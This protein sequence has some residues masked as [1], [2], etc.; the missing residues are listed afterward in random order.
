MRKLQE[1]RRLFIKYLVN[2]H[3]ILY[4]NLADD[5]G[6]NEK[7]IYEVL[8]NKRNVTDELLAN[9]CT[10]FNVSYVEDELFEKEIAN[11]VVLLFTHL[12]KKTDSEMKEIL[13]DLH[14]KFEKIQN[15]SAFYF[16]PIIRWFEFR[17]DT[18]RNEYLVLGQ[19][20]YDHFLMS[21]E[22]AAIFVIL[23]VFDL[24]ITKDT[25]IIDKKLQHLQNNYSFNN[26]PESILGMYYFQKGRVLHQQRIFLEAYRMY[27]LAKVAFKNIYIKER[28]VQ[29]DIQEATIYSDIGEIDKAIEMYKEILSI[30]IEDGF[31]TRIEVCIDNLIDNYFCNGDFEKCEEI[32]ELAKKHNNYTIPSKI[33][34]S[35]ILLAK[36]KINEFRK[37]YKLISK[38]DLSK[39]DSNLLEL[40]H[41][42]CNKNLKKFNTYYP[43]VKSQQL[44][45]MNHYYMKRILLILKESFDDC[46]VNSFIVKEL[47]SIK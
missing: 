43:K 46:E 12:M 35:F 17:K 25:K 9:I 31:K 47:L 13:S 18:N 3:Y 23:Q 4:K 36:N 42:V 40:A 30:S 19:D 32:I 11:D 33:T 41:S 45:L 10:Y 37:L 24:K 7:V 6:Y 22:I 28:V 1:K 26:L 14:S 8:S 38:K 15:S 34:F 39:E 20:Y 16:E 5:L 29:A 27:E 21:N 2:K 44:G